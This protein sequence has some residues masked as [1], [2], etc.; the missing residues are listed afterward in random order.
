MVPD[1]ILT[2]LALGGHD[3]DVVVAVK[4][5]AHVNFAVLFDQDVEVVGV[6]EGNGGAVGEGLGGCGGL[7]SLGSCTN[8]S[9]AF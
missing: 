8:R 7:G 5:A 2:L 9:F 6:H 4:E 3:L 1:R